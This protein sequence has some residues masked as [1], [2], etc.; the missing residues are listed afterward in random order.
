MDTSQFTH[1]LRSLV[2]LTPQQTARVSQY[3]ASLQGL[4]EFSLRLEK[5]INSCPHCNSEHVIHWGHSRGKA[6]FRCKSCNRTFSPLTKTPLA[7]LH[8]PE[9][10]T[11]YAKSMIDGLSIRKSAKGSSIHRN[12]SFRWRHRFL[13]TSA[14]AQAKHLDGITEADETFFLR[15]EKGSRH[16]QR[17][18]RKRGG[19]ASQRGRSKEQVCVLVARDRSGATADFVMDTFDTQQLKAVLKPRLAR[20]ALLCSDGLNVYSALCKNL[21]ISHRIVHDQDGERV[22][23]EVFHIQNVNAYHSRLKS[24]ISRFHGVATHYLGN[25]LGWFRWLDQTGTNA[26]PLVLLL[27]ATRGEQHALVT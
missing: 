10:W 8:Y 13:N 12:T 16:L 19:S 7:G 15:S 24:W 20:D 18:A 2:K 25:Y 9:R 11:A 6:R 17:P 23:Q 27:T 4:P 5:C 1:M 14:T 22:I 21:Q 26:T 3:L